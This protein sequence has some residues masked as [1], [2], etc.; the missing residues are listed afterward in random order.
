MHGPLNPLG[1]SKQKILTCACR[2]EPLR[3]A[4]LHDHGRTNACPSTPMSLNSICGVVREFCELR[5][6]SFASRR[7]PS[8]RT[9]GVCSDC[10]FVTNE[11]GAPKPDATRREDLNRRYRVDRSL[12]LD[13]DSGDSLPFVG[14]RNA[15]DLE[16]LSND[17]RPRNT[18]RNKGDRTDLL[19]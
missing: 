17:F 5:S 15:A 18:T 14:G 19:L 9:W 8:A 1:R 4:R 12:G 2:S 7:K 13:T 11:P 3:S 10:G 16:S 6:I